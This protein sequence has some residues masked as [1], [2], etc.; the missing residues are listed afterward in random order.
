MV[1]TK[2]NL[3]SSGT[4]QKDF[5]STFPCFLFLFL[6]GCTSTLNANLS[7][8]ALVSSGTI[9]IAAANPVL[10]YF[11][12]GGDP[13]C[14]GDSLFSHPSQLTSDA[15]GNIYVA[16]TGCNA[17]RKI[18]PKGVV[19][20]LGSFAGSP[21][22]FNGTYGNALDSAGNLYIADRDN[23][24][25]RMITPA[26]V[27]S[28]VAGGN[29]VGALKGYQDGP[30]GQALFA[31]PSGLAVTPDGNTLYVGDYNNSFIRIITKTAGNWATVSTVSDPSGN[32]FVSSQPRYPAVDASG[33]VYISDGW[34]GLIYKM[35]PTAGGYTRTTLP[36]P[37][38]F[39]FVCPSGLG[40]DSS[41]NLFISDYGGNFVAK[42]NSTDG[43][44]VLA[45]ST[46]GISGSQDGPGS[47]AT[48]WNPITLTVDGIGNVYVG[49]L[50]TAL[51]RKITPSGDV[52]TIA[53][54]AGFYGNSTA[55]SAR[56]STLGAL[57]GLVADPSGNIYVDE[58][59]SASF[60]LKIDTNDSL[61]FYA[62]ASGAQG[63]DDGIALEAPGFNTPQ[64]VAVDTTGN[65]YVA[66]TGNHAIRMIATNG[67]VTT[68]AGQIMNPGYIDGTGGGAQF[69]SPMG[70]AIDS[71][72][73]LY[74]ADTN[75]SAVRKISSG[76]V[77]TTLAGFYDGT[78][79]VNPGYADGTGSEAFFFYPF[80]IASDASGNIYVTDIGNQNI[81]KII[82]STGLTTTFAGPDDGSGDGNPGSSN[83]TGTSASFYNP[84]GIAF[85]AAGNLFVADSYNNEIRKITPDGV[86][87][88]FAGQLASG[89]DLGT[90]STPAYFN[91]PEGV[92]IDSTG[93]IFIL[94]TGNNL[95]L[96]TQE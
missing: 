60:I 72:G 37:T 48:F 82:T 40:F 92:A 94:D 5:S 85:D 44:S 30:V 16:D 77:V 49:D 90:S 39:T 95:I 42:Y 87:T 32:P 51:I 67:T 27:V 20:T 81:R 18:T 66:D 68:L 9:T 75:N 10:N 19:S 8:N 52:S 12:G 31:F 53:G 34:S 63:S 80:G 25:I 56:H 54:Q 43:Y 65:V 28:T 4:Y 86:V 1:S 59:T 46:D 79:N 41:G 11:A 6:S 15:A 23:H 45:G 89:Q 50:T 74:I 2:R 22:S 61:S 26:G 96:Q 3:A 55:G 47:Q 73:N 93:K 88:T 78:G 58:V 57:W 91:N 70:I 69:N 76:G 84:A 64:A 29:L 17:V 38:S 24:A 13:P 35:T 7:I 36:S 33:N 71:K 83:G 62:S 21:A 14:G